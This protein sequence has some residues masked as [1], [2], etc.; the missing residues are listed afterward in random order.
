MK[1]IENPT[2]EEYVDVKLVTEA[3]LVT[4]RQVEQQPRPY[5]SI[6][7]LDEIFEDFDFTHLQDS[8]DDES[9][10]YGHSPDT[11]LAD[12]RYDSSGQSMTEAMQSRQRPASAVKPSDGYGLDLNPNRYNPRYIDAVVE[13]L[14]HS[15][16]PHIEIDHIAM[17]SHTRCCA[18]RSP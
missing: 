11:E 9:S 6:E 3:E 13:M 14:W 18:K 4:G 1:R 2:E 8:T 12:D 16:L 7:D 17:E 15:I 5:L 10:G